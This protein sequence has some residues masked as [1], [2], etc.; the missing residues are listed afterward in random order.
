M[1]GIKKLIL[2]V[3]VACFVAAPIFATAQIATT[4][5]GQIII[6]N[7]SDHT[8]KKFEK[9]TYKEPTGFSVVNPKDIHYLDR[10][11]EKVTL[12]ALGNYLP[13]QNSFYRGTYSTGE[14]YVLDMQTTL[15][16]NMPVSTANYSIPSLTLTD[17]TVIRGTNERLS[18][19]K[20]KTSHG[21]YTSI[22]TTQKL[23]YT[24][25]YEIPLD[26]T[27]KSLTYTDNKGQNPVTIDL[28]SKGAL[29]QAE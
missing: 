4:A 15:E 10:N 26:A 7:S 5:D 21:W 8:Y 28:G 29:P 2:A 12:Q 1:K 9:K 24:V 16:D 20:E 6:L 11:W 3:L 18:A 14:F 17:G 27:P 13:S 23:N 25:V 19:V 22:T